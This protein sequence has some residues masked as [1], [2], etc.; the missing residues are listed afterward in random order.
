MTRDER[1][2]RSKKNLKNRQEQDQKPQQARAAKRHRNREYAVITYFF[3]FIFVAMI[4]Y[5]LY[6]QF[7]K[8]DEFINSPYNSLQDLFSKNV[9]RGEIK[10][11]EGHV[12]AKTDVA[13]DKSETRVYPDGR[14]FAHAVGYAVNGKT[15]IEKQENF[16]LLRSHE[17]FLDQIV[18]DISGNKNIGDNVVTTLDYEAQVSAYKALGDFDGAVIA[19]E[20]S[21]GKIAVMVSKPDFDPNTIAADWDSVNGEGSTA[22]YNRATQGQYAPGSVFKIFTAL[23]YYN[24]NP[25]T[26][27]DY[28]FDCDSQITVD[29]STI[30]C[31]GN[32]S[33]GHEDF[34]TSFAKSCNSS[35]ANIGLSIDNDSLN[36]LCNKM[37]FNKDLPIAFD[38]KKSTFS[39][40][41]S[42]STSL[43]METTIGQGNTLV[44]PLHMCMV[45]GAIC[46]GG[47]L[48]TPY[49]VDHT[50]NAS[51][52]VVEQNEPVKNKTL[53]SNDQADML[54]N[55]MS[56]V[57]SDGTG[58]KLSG[59]SYDA[60]GKTGTAQV[61]DSTDQ[62]NAWF[63]GYAKKDGYE[64]LAI[65]VIV[66]DSGAG[67]TYAVPVAKAVFDTYFN[68]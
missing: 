65:A 56:A 2:T 62:T 5:F 59:Q 7:V 11:E 64:D 26:Y 46:N 3:L 13:S 36:S 49:I 27:N 57:V 60:F 6:F 42:A 1:V 52:A 35:F 33:H 51:G 48:M 37:L 43:T 58:S 4:G 45:A 14:T 20:P 17:F 28:S 25:D 53:L 29:G 24:E 22:L 38:S 50:E 67:S 21:T 63:V 61:S 12:I 55:L 30:H 23:E 41:N 31:A 8:S 10:T 66:E 34:T 9:V 44:S 32:K 47:T 39:L 19:I 68:E 40:D 54:E 15:G 18:N 16:S